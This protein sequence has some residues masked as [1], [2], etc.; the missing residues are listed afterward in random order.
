MIKRPSTCIHIWSFIRT[1][2][3]DL[4]FV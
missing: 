1:H 3:I 2:N 4:P